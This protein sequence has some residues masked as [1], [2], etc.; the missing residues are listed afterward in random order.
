MLRVLLHLHSESATKAAAEAGVCFGRVLQALVNCCSVIP[1]NS[2]L[3]VLHDGL[4][5]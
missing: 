2:G 1:A 5:F 4:T 3:V